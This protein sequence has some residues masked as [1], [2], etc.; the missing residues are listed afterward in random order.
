MGRS[1]PELK[2]WLIFKGFMGF[3]CF[4]FSKAAIQ[5]EKSC[6]LWLCGKGGAKEN[7][8]GHQLVFILCS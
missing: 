1:L 2:T 6:F 5:G 8:Q 4:W 7:I 3:G